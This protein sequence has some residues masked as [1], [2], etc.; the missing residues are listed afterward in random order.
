MQ[1]RSLD[2]G[3]RAWLWEKILSHCSLLGFLKNVF[4]NDFVL[5]KSGGDKQVSYIRSPRF[6]G[7]VFLEEFVYNYL[8]PM[9]A[10]WDVAKWCHR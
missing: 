3:F 9:G 4:L 2:T 1:I 7:C 8:K 5:E 6:A 10:S